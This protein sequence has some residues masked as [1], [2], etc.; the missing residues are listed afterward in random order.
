[1]TIKKTL[2]TWGHILQLYFLPVPFAEGWWW[3]PFEFASPLDK[4]CGTTRP[5]ELGGD[6]ETEEPELLDRGAP[7]KW[8]KWGDDWSTNKNYDK[9]VLHYVIR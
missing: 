2:V 8:G 1:M 3:P 9:L 4:G 7:Y 5:A 6:E